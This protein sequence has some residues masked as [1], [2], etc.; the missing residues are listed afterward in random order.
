MKTLRFLLCVMCFLT[1]RS[2]QANLPK[3]G[4]SNPGKVLFAKAIVPTPYPLYLPTGQTL[5]LARCYAGLKQKSSP[6]SK[7]LKLRFQLGKY[8]LL[9]LSYN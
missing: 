8:L 9:N 4:G 5:P 2:L 6:F 7:P 3:E 1:T